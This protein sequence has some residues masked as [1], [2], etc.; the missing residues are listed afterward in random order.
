MAN[1]GL[2]W[3]PG[4][5]R[6]HAYN[7]SIRVEWACHAFQTQDASWVLVDPIG[8]PSDLGWNDSD[9]PGV[10]AVVAT[11]GNHERAA[12]EWNRETRVRLW[13][14]SGSGLDSPTWHRLPP[15]PGWKDHWVVEDLTGGGPGEVAIRIPSRDLVVFGDAVVNLAARGLEL[16]PDRYCTDPARLRESIRRLVQ[17][18]FARAVFAHGDPI[19]EGASRRID[20]LLR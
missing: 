2:N 17:T 10:S 8:G 1:P 20:A 11:N 13:A 12:L 19:E 5:R 9:R 15:G 14:A 6:W 7:A 18:P 16:L 4:V 3:L